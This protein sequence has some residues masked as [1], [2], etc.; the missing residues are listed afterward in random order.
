MYTKA[1]TS[2]ADWARVVKLVN[3]LSPEGFWGGK[4]SG[5]KT[6][7]ASQHKGDVIFDYWTSNPWHS[8]D[9]RILP[10]D[11]VPD[12]DDEAHAE[13][14]KAR[15]SSRVALASPAACKAHDDDY[16]DHDYFDD[17]ISTCYDSDGSTRLDDDDADHD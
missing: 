2:G 9:P 14:G 13:A 17:D 11:G 6:E 10:K 8:N 5:Y 12:D 15:G 1:F 7:L 4:K 16:N 3:H